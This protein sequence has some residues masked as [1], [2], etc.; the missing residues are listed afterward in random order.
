MKIALDA[1]GL[2]AAREAYMRAV[3]KNDGPS[4]AVEA[5]LQAYLSISGSKSVKAIV[6][7]GG[8]SPN[9]A[10]LVKMAVGD[11]LEL[12]KLSQSGVRNSF[13]TARRAM[14]NPN[15]SWSISRDTDHILVRRMPDGFRGR[16]PRR[17][18]M[19]VSLADMD[20]GESKLIQCANISRHRGSF[21]N[22]KNQAR[23]IL[24]DESARWSYK[25]TSKGARITRRPPDPIAADLRDIHVPGDVQRIARLVIAKHGVT[26]EQLVSAARTGRLADARHEF[27]GRVHDLPN[28]N[29]EPRYTKVQIGKLVGR[30]DHS[31]INNSIARWREIKASSPQHA[32]AA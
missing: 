21:E 3:Q 32:D 16:D 15:A 11:V 13:C 31:T 9:V 14:E 27:I 29:G 5:V 12:S 6:R 30:R 4:A 19:A 7:A 18:Q 26:A 22:A 23:R 25:I 28:R 20:E 17:N 10:L 8:V 1:T 2:S 24:N